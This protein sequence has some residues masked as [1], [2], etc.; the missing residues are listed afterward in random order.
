[1][2]RMAINLPRRDFFKAAGATAIT[3]STPFATQNHSQRIFTEKVYK[4]A[5]K[6]SEKCLK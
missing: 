1:M 5:N 3:S 2:R 6:Y 4:E